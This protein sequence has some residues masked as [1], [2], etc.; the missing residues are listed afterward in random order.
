M[1][2]RIRADTPQFLGEDLKEYG[3]FRAGDVADLPPQ[4]ARVLIRHGYAEPA[5]GSILDWV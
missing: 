3:P 4:A 2:V 5:G 1:R